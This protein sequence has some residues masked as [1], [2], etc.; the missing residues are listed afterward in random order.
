LRVR[1]GVSEAFADGGRNALA[2]AARVGADVRRL[3]HAEAHGEI[4]NGL[5]DENAAFRC[6]TAQALGR[7]SDTLGDACLGGATQGGAAL[8]GEDRER[9]RI[10]DDDGHDRDRHHATCEGVEEF[11]AFSTGAVNT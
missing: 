3:R 5:G 9:D 2:S 8:V 1:G 10:R 11:H 4:A 6:D 7:E